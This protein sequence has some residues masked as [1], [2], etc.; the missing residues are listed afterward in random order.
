MS[1]MSFGDSHNGF[2]ILDNW[3]QSQPDTNGQRECLQRVT[4]GR[5][6]TLEQELWLAA[7]IWIRKVTNTL[8]GYCSVSSGYERPQ[9]CWR[10]E[11]PGV[12]E[13]RTE[14]YDKMTTIM[15]KLVVFASRPWSG[16]L[17]TT[18]SKR[19]LD[20]QRIIKQNNSILTVSKAI[21]WG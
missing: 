20:E 15:S 19:F 10:I 3:R 12:T 2:A 4:R 7:T 8:G 6:V 11:E 14:S 18:R 5:C 1:K 9:E 13:Q 16:K 21:D 17:E